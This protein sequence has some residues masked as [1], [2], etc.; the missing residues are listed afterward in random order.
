M[1]H[2]TRGRRWT[3]SE[4]GRSLAPTQIHQASFDHVKVGPTPILALCNLWHNLQMFL[5]IL[6]FRVENKTNE[7][8]KETTV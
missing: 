4:N 8:E 5:D 1:G 6:E 7:I 3:F 2:V